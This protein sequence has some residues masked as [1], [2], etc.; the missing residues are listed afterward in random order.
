MPVH[1][2]RLTLGGLQGSVPCSQ[3]MLTNLSAV[4]GSTTLCTVAMVGQQCLCTIAPFGSHLAPVPPRTSQ[5]APHSPNG[6]SSSAK[7]TPTRNGLQD[8]NSN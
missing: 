4:G 2:N 1:G 8:R 6:G 3:Y 7:H 5:Q